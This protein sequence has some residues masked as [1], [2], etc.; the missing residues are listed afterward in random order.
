MI[1][2]LLEAVCLDGDFC[3]K[4]IELRKSHGFNNPRHQALDEDESFARGEL[5]AAMHE[6]VMAV[7]ESADKFVALVRDALTGNPVST[8]ELRRESVSRDS[9]A[10]RSDV[11]RGL[12]ASAGER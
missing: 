12:F 4:H 6:H 3:Q 2:R 8:P 7:A 5:E 1:N 9:W 11:L 10:A